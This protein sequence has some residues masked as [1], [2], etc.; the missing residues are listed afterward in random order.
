MV[1]MVL[2]QRLLS[3]SDRALD[4]LQLL[5]DVKAGAPG[6]DHLDDLAQMTVGSLQ[7]LYDG[8]VSFVNVRL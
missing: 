6:F 7:P 8:R 4:R 3:L 2:D 5:G 1:E